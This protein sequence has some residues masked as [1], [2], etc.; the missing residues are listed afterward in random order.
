MIG[1]ELAVPLGA[2]CA[3]LA[4]AVG[5]WLAERRSAHLRRLWER[6]VIDREAQ[7]TRAATSAAS[8]TCAETTA[9][10]ATVKACS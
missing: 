10:C 6:A 8:C 9:A 2:L 7:A 1:A 3:A 4:F 5:D